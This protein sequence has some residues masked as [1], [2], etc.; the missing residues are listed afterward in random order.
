VIAVAAIVVTYAWVMTYMSNATN[1]AGV[2]L[3]PAANPDFSGSAH[4]QI[5]IDI[6]NKG[7]S[8]AH[9]VR[10]YIGTSSSTMR[11]QNST[12]LPELCPAQGGIAT[13]MVNYDWMPGA[14]YYFQVVAREQ[15][16][17]P[18]AFQAPTS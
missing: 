5:S 10:I 13:I 9:L 15:T 2:N 18:W 1:Q 12:S 11:S 3:N 7:T 17:G 16:A 8:D 4:D 6:Q 14:T